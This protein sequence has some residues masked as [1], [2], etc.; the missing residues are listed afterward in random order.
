MF[1]KH[2]FGMRA[3]DLF[4]YTRYSGSYLYPAIRINQ[5]P[6]AIVSPKVQEISYPISS[7]FIDGNRK[8]QVAIV[9]LHYNLGMW[10][11]V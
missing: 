5:P 10:K 11:S 6:V 7:T 1:S 8:Y 9:V 2:G 3:V 4:N